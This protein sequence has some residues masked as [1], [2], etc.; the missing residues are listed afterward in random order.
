M[1]ASTQPSDASKAGQRT[2]GSKPHPDTEA[3]H[4][5]PRNFDTPIVPHLKKFGIFDIRGGL[6]VGEGIRKLRDSS[7]RFQTLKGSLFISVMRLQ[8]DSSGVSE[9]DALC[10][11]A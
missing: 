3:R 4:P 8:V 10:C 11:S 2:L 7:V 5:P 1:P 9:G 6:M